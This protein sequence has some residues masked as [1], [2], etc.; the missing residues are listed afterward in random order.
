MK[1]HIISALPILV[2]ASLATAG[3]YVDQKAPIIEEAP[4]AKAVSGSLSLDG[5][6][7]FISYGTD[8][9]GDGT[10]INEYAFNPA[11]ELS[12]AITDE[13]SAYI[14]TWWDVNDKGQS[15]IGGSLQEVDVWT[16]L[17]LS[18][19]IFSISATYQSWFYGGT[20]EEVLDIGLGLDV[21]LSPSLTVHQRLDPGAS[22]GDEGTVIVLGAEY[23]FDIGAVSLAIPVGLGFFAT[24]GY[25]GPGAD[26]GFGYAT[27]GLAAS[28]PLAFLDTTLGGEWALN[29]GATY[30]Y[31][32][33]DVTVNNP[34]ENFVV[35]NFGLGLSF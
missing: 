17:A 4:E 6:S 33:S 20:T 8:V 31:T 14:G 18:K 7:H 22:G 29:L 3:E 19:G 11:F 9:W 26:D 28:Y 35:T 34:E 30:Y 25:H 2:G 21:F 12:F 13:L 16:G 5:Y 10:D 1:K 32:D 15:L 24:D 27:V 23:G